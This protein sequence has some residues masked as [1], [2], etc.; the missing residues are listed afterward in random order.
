MT[1]KAKS[2][3]IKE[4]S[5]AIEDLQKRTP[6][7]DELPLPAGHA[8]FKSQWLGWLKEYLGPGY[9]DRTNVH[10]DAKWT[11]Q[12]LNNGGSTRRPAR[13]LESLGR[14]SSQSTAVTQR[15]RKPCMPAA[16]C[17][18]RAWRSGCSNKSCSCPLSNMSIC[19]GC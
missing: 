16:S 6:Q 2:Y 15:R 1:T 13:I 9:Y 14:R 7:S 18:G 11:Y 3:S 17:P 10:D 5:A 4:F 19:R 8:S 12:H